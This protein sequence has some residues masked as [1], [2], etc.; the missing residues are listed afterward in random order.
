[1]RMSCIHVGS[2]TSRGF[3]AI[4]PLASTFVGFMIGRITVPI[5]L[6]T[7]R[8]LCLATP[9]SSR[10]LIDK[11]LCDAATVSGV[12]EVTQ[13]QFWLESPGRVVTTIKVRYV[14]V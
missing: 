3:S 14:V 1:M 5:A 9:E 4:D 7:G 13:S 8:V 12:L 11:A 2:L 10:F 6:K